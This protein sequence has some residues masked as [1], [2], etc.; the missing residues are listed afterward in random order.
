MPSGPDL[1]WLSFCYDLFCLLNKN[2]LS[3]DLINR[4]KDSQHFQG[5]RY[6]LAVAAIILRANCDIK[7]INKDDFSNKTCEFKATHKT[8]GIKFVVE[9]KSKKRPGVLNEPGIPLPE[10]ESKG[11]ASLLKD[12]L[13]KDVPS[14]AFF[15]IFVDDNLPFSVCSPENKAILREVKRA[16]GTLSEDKDIFNLLVITSFPF[17]YGENNIPALPPE[18]LIVLPN[19]NDYLPEAI[20]KD[21]GLSLK[22][23]AKIPEE[24]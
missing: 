21:L 11:F 20:F 5:A 15:V 24:I 19:N 3:L 4:L 1:F 10:C 9:A 23:Y 7:W 6:E 8:S 13:K 22:T 16:I 18:N 2:V 14:G 17:H 12:A